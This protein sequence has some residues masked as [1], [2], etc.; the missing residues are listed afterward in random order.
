[1]D[2]EL[3]RSDNEAKKI[4][5]VALAGNPNVGKSTLFNG[6]TGLRQHTGNWTGKTVGL[7]FGTCKKARSRMKIVD[8]PGTYSL[9]ARSEEERIA[10]DY[11]V[12]GE[13]D[14]IA[15]VC[16]ATCL[17]RNL[18]LVLQIL[19][20]TRNVVVCVN[21][22]D[23]A[24]RKG[25]EVDISALEERLG[26]PVIEICARKK[27][28]ILKV[29]ELF[30]TVEFFGEQSPREKK[31][32]IES[33]N[34]AEIA[35]YAVK[36]RDSK[37]AE[38]DRKIDRVLTS[39]IWGFPIMALLLCLVLWITAVGANIPSDL[40]SRALFLVQ[41]ILLSVFDALHAPPLLRDALILGV[42]RTVAWVVA[43]MLPPMAI[44]FPLFTLLEDLGYLPRVAFNLDRCFK[45][46]HACGKQALTMCKG[47]NYLESVYEKNFL[48]VIGVEF[49]RK[50][51]LCADLRSARR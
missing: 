37:G 46:C 50:T 43:V 29:A 32:D 47:K 42:Y 26:V 9:C 33:L 38:R 21:L 39:K 12:N 17:E 30:E 35:E 19:R 44:F 16:D 27:S 34:P 40:L 8:L 41:D 24:K 10:R 28:C 11:I 7:A 45:G 3:L 2:N 25:I 20:L 6:L 4:R 36:R 31:V 22:I 13:A 23:E 49:Y 14:I 18:I 1:M 15:V 48:Y 51:D 5:T